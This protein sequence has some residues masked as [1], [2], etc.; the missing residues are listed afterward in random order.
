MQPQQGSLSRLLQCK[1]TGAPAPPSQVLP[2]RWLPDPDAPASRAEPL[3]LLLMLM[4]CIKLEAC[5][6]HDSWCQA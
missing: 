5:R 3:L 6:V 1:H 4:R 2:F